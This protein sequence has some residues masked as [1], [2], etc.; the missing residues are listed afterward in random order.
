[1][2]NYT[3]SNALTTC[4]EWNGNTF[5]GNY[6]VGDLVTGAVSGAKAIMES[7]RVNLG[8]SPNGLNFII[9]SG[10]PFSAGE[11]VNFS[12]GGSCVISSRISTNAKNII[13]VTGLES[14]VSASST[15]ESIG[16][17]AGVDIGLTINDAGGVNET[18]N[19][20]T[21]N[22][23]G[24][25]T[26]GDFFLCDS[27]IVRCSNKTGNDINL[28]RGLYGSGR[29]SHVDG[30]TLYRVSFTITTG[31]DVN[32]GDILLIDSEYMEVMQRMPNNQVYCHE[33]GVWG[34]TVATH[35][36]A[37][38]ID[39]V[40]KDFFYRVYAADQASGWGLTSLV[41]NR[42][43][44]DCD[45]II[46]DPE[47]ASITR[48]LTRAETAII[49]GA[50]MPCGGSTYDTVFQSGLGYLDKKQSNVDGSTIKCQNE[51]FISDNILST[52]FGQAYLYASNVSGIHFFDGGIA[53]RCNGFPY[54]KSDGSYETTNMTVY[55][56]G[57]GVQTS[58]LRD[59]LVKYG[60]FNPGSP[61]IEFERL[62]AGDNDYGL[63][64]LTSGAAE[65]EIYDL[66]F[67]QSGDEAFAFVD[68]ANKYIINPGAI[69]I[70][71]WS[72]FWS[73]A[74]YW[75]QY[76]VDML[77]QTAEGTPVQNVS[78][79]AWNNVP[80][81][82]VSQTTG[83]DGTITQQII[84][85]NY[86]PDVSAKTNYEPIKWVISKRGWETYIF[87]DTIAE[88][89]EYVITLQNIR[90]QQGDDPT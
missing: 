47:Q 57:Y 12:S 42:A 37:T 80:T 50:I 31:T 44:F 71:L 10:G 56:F 3:I 53:Q 4:E 64:F 24:L 70:G 19:P 34:S 76:T 89:K 82:I 28:A 25:V 61:R 75:E 90:N 85:R 30:S 23:G 54:P 41:N 68:G 26:I 9:K 8:G 59:L 81:N 1:M 7:L 36:S 46:G 18:D 6:A 20:W 35:T 15:T 78:V 67:Y 14:A 43:V 29:A 45:I 17:E 63:Y 16:T 22:N 83:A 39:V 72:G 13:Q 5:S 58:Y 62:I 21:V 55:Q 32:V 77:V 73:A 84:T 65:P 51:V 87:E 66:S 38:A 69:N 27:E 88:Q 33:R 11:T 49:T 40:D 48:A 60:A 2:A 79:K 86:K 74:F 52:R